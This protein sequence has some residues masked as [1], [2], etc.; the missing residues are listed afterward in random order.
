MLLSETVYRIMDPGG[1]AE[2]ERVAEKL[3]EDLP[4]FARSP[5]CLQWS[6]D[7]LPQRCV[8]PFLH[9]RHPPL[10]APSQDT[11]YRLLSEVF[12]RIYLPSSA[13]HGDHWLAG[14]QTTA[15]LQQS[16]TVVRLLLPSNANLCWRASP[17]KSQVP[18]GA[19]R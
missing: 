1:L 11:W 7:H 3:M 16:S 6:P 12:I 9:L 5:L 19:E 15:S 8:T 18:G 2:A 17:L 4:A 14:T 13:N 10:P